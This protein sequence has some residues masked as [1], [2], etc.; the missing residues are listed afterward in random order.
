MTPEAAA[1]VI[2]LVDRQSPY[3]APRTAQDVLELAQTWAAS[4]DDTM[5]LQFALRAVL[6]FYR[7]SSGGISPA[8]LNAMWRAEVRYRQS[9]AVIAE[10]KAARAATAPPSAE[11]L[12]V[13]RRLFGDRDEA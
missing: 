8:D 2:R 1:D 10:A 6:D 12:E 9:R 11:Y 5:P 13:K 3:V 7:N 4:L